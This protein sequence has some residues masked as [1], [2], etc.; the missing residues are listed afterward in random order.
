MI[1]FSGL[2]GVERMMLNLLEGIAAEGHAVDLLV[3]KKL[4]AGTVLPDNVRVIE[5]GVNHTALA[6]IPLIRYLKRNK[7]RAM[8]AAKDRAIRM[9][10]LARRLSG[11]PVYLAG[12][13][14]TNLSAALQGRSRLTRSLRLLP[15]R[16]FYRQVD[17]VVAVSDGVATDTLTLTGLPPERISVIRNPVITP[18]M[19]QT[20]TESVSHPWLVETADIPVILGAG[21]L[22]EQK[23]FT[24]LINAFALLRQREQRPYRLI[25]LGHGKL[26]RELESLIAAL[27]LEEDVSL[28]GHVANP[29]SYM[30]KASVFVLSSRWEGSPNV[31]TEAMALGVPVVATDCPS[32][33]HELLDGGRYGPLVPV[34]D[35]QRLAQ[36]I[37][38]TL[39]HP[40]AAEALQ[41]A[42]KAYRMDFSSRRY[43]EAMKLA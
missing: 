20:S 31:L 3:I 26:R 32:G 19:R 25:I 42:V 22:T 1:S 13:L 28:P 41:D 14:G 10:A 8:L 38:H 11:N 29:Y 36:A 23:D 15:M 30:A 39:E 7:P 2:G 12:R 6:L 27:A 37:A 43:L 24:T 5:L 40:P 35:A 18:S 17:H 4:P 16:W 9:A 33:P 34:G 21:R